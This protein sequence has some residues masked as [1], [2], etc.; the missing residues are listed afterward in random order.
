MKSKDTQFAAVKLT[1]KQETRNPEKDWCVRGKWCTIAGMAKLKNTGCTLPGR[2]CPVRSGVFS[3]KK[4]RAREI[5]QA[6]R[7]RVKVR[8]RQS[9]SNVR[10]HESIGTCVRCR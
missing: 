6:K 1:Y 8:V 9:E 3:R 5:D 4:F 7:S 10:D 2:P